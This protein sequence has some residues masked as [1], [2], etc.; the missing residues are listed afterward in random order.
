MQKTKYPRTFNLPNS[1]SDTSDDVWWSD[2]KPF[3][4]KD[5][6]ITEKLDGENTTI[7]PDGSVHARSLDSR[8]HPSRSWIKSYASEIGHKIPDGLRV[9]GEN[10]YAFH[11]I[12]YTE[13]DTYFY[14]FGIYEGEQ[15]LSWL[16]TKEICDDIGLALVPIIYEGEWKDDLVKDD[17]EKSGRY[18][19]FKLKKGLQPEYPN[20][21]EPCNAEGF[22]IR[23][24]DTFQYQDFNKCCAKYVSPQFRGLMRDT[25]W[26]STAVFPNRKAN[27]P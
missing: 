11:S 26:A 18:P 9:C 23:L 14:V 2:F 6:V 21:F 13:L 4:G 15:C 27:N 20:N 5:V 7:Y 16:D 25:H 19:T 3:E 24:Q 22:V 17:L 1:G 12:L 8:H 10:M